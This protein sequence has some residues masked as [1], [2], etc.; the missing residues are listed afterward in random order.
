MRGLVLLIVVCAAGPAAAHGD[1]SPWTNSTW[2][3]DP[4]IIASAVTAL[5]VIAG[6]AAYVPARRALHIDPAVALRQD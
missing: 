5:F 3:Y 4:W 2:T 1:A 6:V